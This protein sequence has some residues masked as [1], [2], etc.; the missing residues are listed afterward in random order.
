MEAVWS[1]CAECVG[2]LT[3]SIHHLPLIHPGDSPTEASHAMTAA[4]ES[5]WTT[6]KKR[7]DPILQACGWEVVSFRPERP[8]TA[9]THHAAREVPTANGPADYAL[10][11]DGRLLGVVEA[12]KLTLG[13]QN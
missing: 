7:I 10:V 13:P 9:Y 6:R 4:S 5:E 1:P 3:S 12:K 8:L 11:V 2:S